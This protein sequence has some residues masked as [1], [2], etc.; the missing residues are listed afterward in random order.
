[1]NVVFKGGRLTVC[2]TSVGWLVFDKEGLPC[3]Y[4]VAEE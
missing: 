3:L 4:K 1:M 2:V